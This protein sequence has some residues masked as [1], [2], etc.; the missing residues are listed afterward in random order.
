MFNRFLKIVSAIAILGIIVPNFSLAITA[1][2]FAKQIEQWQYFKDVNI[3]GNPQKG[4]LVK[5][6]LDQD[7]FS[8]AKEDLGDLRVTDDNLIEVPYKLIIERSAF[9]QENIYPVVVINNSYN[10]DGKYN[11]FVVDF[12]QGGFLNSSLN[13]LTSSENFKR[14]VEISGSND[15]NGWNILKNNGYIYDYTDRVGNF[16]AQNTKVD[17]PENAFRYIQVKIFDGGETPLS[18]TGAQVSKIK[19]SESKETVFSPK[20]DVVENSLKKITEVVVDLGKK[21]WPT[22][23]ITL[24]SPDENF[25]REILVYE[26]SD[27]NN[28]RRVGESYIFNYNTP[29]FVGSNLEVG[30]SETRERYLKIE[31][32]NG[33]NSP[34]NISG[35][36]TKTILRSIAFQ[37]GVNTAGNAYKLY[38]GNSK[39]DFPQYD[40]EKF[41][42]YLDTGIYFSSSLSAEQI[43]SFYAKEVPPEAPLTERIP[44]L[45]PGV[46]VLAIAMMGLM[47]FKFIKKV[48]TENR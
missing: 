45:V 20:Y 15:M 4:D 10:S 13:I 28:W 33:D 27:K 19:R 43:N 2:G 16:K 1:G 38:Y 14:T 30:Y 18:I 22:S 44:Y 24:A 9:S 3:S 36:S 40:L 25:N 31:I 11:I 42:S 46:L 37:Y 26:S 7:V 23:N 39:A 6:T 17:Y 5:I 35:I 12:G 8:N 48:G 29:K 32:F 34:I 21:G 47:V 41:F